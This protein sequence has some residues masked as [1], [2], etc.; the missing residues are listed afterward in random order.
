VVCGRDLAACSKVSKWAGRE[1]RKEGERGTSLL[2]GMDD[3][4][5]LSDAE[6]ANG[7]SED[8]FAM[9]SQQD[10]NSDSMNVD[11]DPNPADDVIDTAEM[12]KTF[13]HL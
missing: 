3:D 11:E 10:N 7:E 6:S 1:G 12:L 5:F 9:N 13:K 8:E 4:D 2:E